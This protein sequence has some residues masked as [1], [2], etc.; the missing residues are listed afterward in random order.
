MTRSLHINEMKRALGHRCAHI[1]ET[2]PGEPPEDGEMN[3]MTM[4]SRH[5][6][7]GRARYLSVTEAPHNTEFYTWMWK[8]QFCLF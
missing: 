1:G 8:K 6:I 5:R 3:E 7:Q 4:F 2:G